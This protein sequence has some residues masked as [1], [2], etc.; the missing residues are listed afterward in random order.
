MTQNKFNLRVFIMA[1]VSL[2]DDAIILTVVI[3]ILSRFVHLPVWLIVL[4]ALLFVGWAFMSYFAIRKSPQLGFENM[5]GATGVTLDS[6]TPK[7]TIRI[8]HERWAARARGDHIGA[9]VAVLVVGQS[10]LLLTVVKKEQ[11]ESS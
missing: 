7:G 4:I 6:L 5:V 2:L 1:A 9:G 11:M 3:L 8:D 10:G